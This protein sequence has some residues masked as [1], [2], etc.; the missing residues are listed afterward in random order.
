M[1]FYS[2]YTVEYSKILFLWRCYVSLVVIS[3]TF[4]FQFTT[5]LNVVTFPCQSTV[6]YPLLLHISSFTKNKNKIK[7]K[8]TVHL[9]SLSSSQ[10][11]PLFL[12]C[13]RAFKRIMRIIFKV[14]FLGTDACLP[15]SR[16]QLLWLKV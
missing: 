9:Q 3:S 14:A 11:I 16:R 8:L 1:S 5:S 2:I 7:K 6:D 13:F 12:R 4:S 15:N 10:R